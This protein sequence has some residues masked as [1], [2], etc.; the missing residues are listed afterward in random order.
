MEARENPAVNVWQAVSP[1]YSYFGLSSNWSDGTPTSDDVLVFD[2]GVSNIG[3]IFPYTGGYQY[4]GLKFLNGYTGTVTLPADITFGGYWQTCGNTVQTA[5]YH[6]VTVTDTFQWTGGVI[7]NGLNAATY[8]LK[9]ITSGQIGTDSST[10]YSGSKFVL[11]KNGSTGTVVQQT[12]VLHLP[13]GSDI[14]ILADCELLQRQI[15]APVN[16][17]FEIDTSGNVFVAGAGRFLSEGGKVPSVKVDPLGMLDVQKRNGKGGLT[18]TGKVPG[19]NWGVVSRGTII[20]RNGETITATHGVAVT[21]G[22][23]QTET[24]PNGVPQIVTINGRFSFEGNWIRLGLSNTLDGTELANAYSTLKVTK[25]ADLLVGDFWTK[26]DATNNQNRDAID[27]DEYL[28]C[29]S[30]FYIEPQSPAPA[31][32]T[33]VLVSKNGF[34]SSINPTNADPTNFTM[35]RTASGKEWEVK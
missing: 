4:A 2:G 26:L 8:D 21:A 19:S 25:N 9:G 29:D 11:E 12:G 23:F 6:T 5:A 24:A 1:Y 27:T 3:T 20:V 33:N 10:L 32:G 17:G 34:L 22:D 35:G 15:N 31:A 7:N 30:S 14:E 18:V 16:S 13:N 28:N